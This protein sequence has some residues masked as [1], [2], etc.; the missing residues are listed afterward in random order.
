MFGLLTRTHRIAPPVAPRSFR[1]SLER[2]ET[3]DCPS[4]VMLNVAYEAG[5]QVTLYG[6]VT[7]AAGDSTPGYVGPLQFSGL[8]GVTVVFRGSANGTALTDSDGNFSLT[9]NAASLG[10]VDAATADGQS[11]MASVFLSSSAPVISNFGAF[12]ESNTRW[13]DVV[14]HVTDG[15]FSPQ[16]L[17]IQING[18]PV[19][20]YNNGQGQTTSVDQN[21]N[22][23]LIIQL[24][25]TGKDNGNIQASTTDAWGLQ[26][27]APMFMISQPGT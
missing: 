10:E 14:G 21:G 20:I 5:K 19:T 17:T 13:W 18:S 11:N 24:N 1:P 27:N 9:T 23:D 6:Q 12:Q 26:S 25:G 2:L 3:R 16:G 4:T 8:V 22:F 7:G 15:N